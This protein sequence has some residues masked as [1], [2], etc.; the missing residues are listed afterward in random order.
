M[1]ADSCRMKHDFSKGPPLMWSWNCSVRTN[2]GRHSGFA[3]SNL[4]FKMKQD[5]MCS[6]PEALVQGT[7]VNVSRLLLPPACTH[8]LHRCS[9]LGVHLHM[10]SADCKGRARDFVDFRCWQYVIRHRYVNSAAAAQWW[11][12]WL[13]PWCRSLA[14]LSAP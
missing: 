1:D 12:P 3:G 13:G 5:G 4:P 8:A 9:Q 10:P 7:A 14:S 11:M 6:S 2:S